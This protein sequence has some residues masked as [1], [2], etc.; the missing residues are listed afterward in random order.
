[1]RYFIYAL[2]LTLALLVS[3][4]NDSWLCRCPVHRGKFPSSTHWVAVATTPVSLP[5]SDKKK[6]FQAL[7]KVPCRTKLALVKVKNHYPGQRCVTGRVR[8]CIPHHLVNN[9]N[10]GFDR[11]PA[12]FRSALFLENYMYLL[13]LCTEEI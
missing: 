1:M 10:H 4:P 11:R 5:S 12:A 8:A 9:Q 3:G 7:S 13:I 6:C 2:D